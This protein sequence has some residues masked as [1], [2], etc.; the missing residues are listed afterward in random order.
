MH[1]INRMRFERFIAARISKPE[2]RSFSSIIAK[3]AVGSVAIGVFIM[4]ISY[5]ILYGFQQKIQQKIFSFSGQ[6]QLTKYDISASLKE[7]PIVINQEFVK[8]CKSHYNVAGVALYSLKAGLIKTEEEVI[9][10]VIK[11]V[12]SSYNAAFFS[13]NLIKGRFLNFDKDE[14][15]KE[16][17]ISRKMADKLK[18]NINEELLVFFVQDP[19]R[20]RKLKIVGIYETGLEEFDEVIMMGDLNLLRK[21]NNWPDN[22]AGG[23]EIMLRDMTKI[24]E[25]SEY[26]YDNMDFDVGLEKVTDKYITIFDWLKLLDNNVKIFLALIIAVAAFNMVSS[27]F[28]MVLERTNMIGT[29]KALGASNATINR[30]FYYNGLK[31]VVTGLLIGNG[32]ALLFCTIQYYFHVIPLDPE[33]YYME[34][35]PISWEWKTFLG[36]NILLFLKL[37]AALFIP[38]LLISRIN[39]IKSI[40]F[41]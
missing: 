33:N 4:V 39:P 40:K 17:V 11:G 9:G 34:W 23:Y 14:S 3:I 32:I 28:I 8:T 37:N 19:P 15:M 27:L 24:D 12:D 16:I 26:V 36:V 6:I 31:L 18:T 25:T 5:A 38:H 13:Q 22:Y 20:Y 10:T 41:D 1:K 29:L 21:I 35:V 30:I 2:K 7:N